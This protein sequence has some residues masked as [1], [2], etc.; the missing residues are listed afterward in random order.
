MDNFKLHTFK[1]IKLHE[2]KVDFVSQK[3]KTTKMLILERE[4]NNEKN[5]KFINYVDKVF[6]FFM[7]QTDYLH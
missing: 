2:K 6:L 7:H 5:E 3:M 1:K 4:L